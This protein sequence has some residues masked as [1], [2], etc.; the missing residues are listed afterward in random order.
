MVF[1]EVRPQPPR[2]HSPRERG[3]EAQG[4][5]STTSISLSRHRN[6]RRRSGKKRVFVAMP[7]SEEFQDTF[8]FGIDAPVRARGF[9]PEKVDET[10]FT[11]D[12]LQRIKDGIESAEFLIADLTGAR[13]NV[14]LEVG[15]AWGHRVPVIFLARHGEKLHFDVSTHRCIYYKSIRHL[16]SELDRLIDDLMERPEA[17]E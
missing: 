11:G 13:P 6:E 15:Y 4:Q 3:T 12:I 9:I 10:S 17:F 2:F 8:I 14:Y 5:L 7:F 16:A 1:P